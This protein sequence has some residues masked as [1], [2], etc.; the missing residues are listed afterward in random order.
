MSRGDVPK[1]Q[2]VVYIIK[3]GYDVTMEIPRI[4]LGKVLPVI[5]FRLQ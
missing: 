5:G 2:M 1:E 3:G 4:L